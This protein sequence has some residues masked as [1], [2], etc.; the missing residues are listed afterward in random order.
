MNTFLNTCFSILRYAPGDYFYIKKPIELITDVYGYL[1]LKIDEHKH[2]MKER[3]SKMEKDE[4][5]S[6]Y[7]DAYLIEAEKLDMK[8][9]K[10]NHL[11]HGKLI[12]IIISLIHPLVFFRVIY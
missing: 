4:E 3:K 11:F 10:N 2:E 9:G 8:F 5:L 1:Q 12:F 7:I 6:N